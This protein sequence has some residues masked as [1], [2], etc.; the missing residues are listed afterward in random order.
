M[1]YRTRNWNWNRKIQAQAE[2]NIRRLDAEIALAIEERRA[3]QLT[4]AMGNTIE[5]SYP[6]SGGF[7]TYTMTITHITWKYEEDFKFMDTVGGQVN[8][9][10]KDF[11]CGSMTNI[12][13]VL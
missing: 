13:K 2:K 1:S 10:W 12:S 9:E 7:V 4:V 5:F 3:S 11:D 6:E 8:G